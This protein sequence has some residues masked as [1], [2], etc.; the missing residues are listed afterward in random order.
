MPI[1]GGSLPSVTLS[2]PMRVSSIDLPGAISCPLFDAILEKATRLCGTAFGVDASE[3]CALVRVPHPMTPPASYIFSLKAIPADH[4]GQWRAWTSTPP[5]I[6][7]RN[8]C[9]SIFVSSLGCKLAAATDIGPWLV[10]LYT[11]HLPY[12]PCPSLI[13]ASVKVDTSAGCGSWMAGSSPGK[14]ALR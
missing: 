14:G 13:L 6:G 1:Y 9:L 8:R 2:L 10:R 12:S 11:V 7:R 4:A 5:S 3:H